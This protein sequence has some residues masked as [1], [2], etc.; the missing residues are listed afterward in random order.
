MSSGVAK[1]LEQLGLGQYAESFEKNAIGLEHL[2]DL[3]HETL[4]EI[5][6]RAVGHRMS[7]LK[8][9]ANLRGQLHAKVA[10]ETD[11]APP[12][13][14]SAEAERRQL[15][16]MFCDLVGS[17]ELSARLDPE[18]MRE[19]LQ[20]YQ[21]TCAAT[22][23][24]YE[25]YIAR[26]VGDGL[27]VYF[28][29]PRAH[30]DDPQR[31]VRAGLAI[32]SDIEALD[33]DLSRSDVTLSVRIGINTGLVVVGDIGSGKRRDT[34]AIV[35]E[36]PNVAARLQALAEP[37]TVVIGESTKRLVEG[38]FVCEELG[39]RQLKGIPQP[40]NAYRPRSESELRTRFEATAAR[41]LT[42]LVGREQEVALLRERWEHAKEGDGQVVLLSG[43]AGI[44]KS[45]VVRA[46]QD[47]IR[48]EARNRVLYYCSPYH[49]NSALYPAIDQMERALRFEK[50]EGV[51]HRLEK[52][53][54]VLSDLGLP[55]NEHAPVLASLLSLPGQGRYPP[56]ALSPE[57]ARGRSLETI[58]AVLG[59][60]ASRAP[61]LMAVEDA[62]WADASTLE[63]LGLVTERASSMALLLIITFRPEFSLPWPAHGGHVTTISLNRLT[64][65]QTVALV[66][67]MVRDDEAL[68]GDLAEHIVA[69]TDGVPLFVEELTKAV[70]E[71]QMR[72]QAR[73]AQTPK[74][75][76]SVMNIP[77]SLQDSLM[78]RLDR[79]GDVKEIAQLGATI[80]R[81]FSFELLRA[82]SPLPEETLSEALSR[83]V[84]SELVYRRSIAPEIKYEF[85]HALV[86]DAAYASLLKSKRQQHHQEIADALE[87]H[88]PHIAKT[89][90]A[91]VA[92]H[93][94]EGGLPAQAV[95]YW[96]KAGE[97]LHARGSIDMSIEAY[98]RVLDLAPDD[99]MRCRG[100]MGVAAGLRILDRYEEALEALEQA[101]RAAEACGLLEER[102]ALHHLRGNLYFPLG[103][104]EAC[105]EQHEL[106][107]RYAQRAESPEAE[108]RAFGG[109]G[110]AEYARGRMITAHRYFTRCVEV[111]RE[112]GFGSI[113]AANAVMLGAAEYYF[114]PSSKVL[115]SAR[116]ALDIAKR[117]GH[118]RAEL[119]SQLLV[120]RMLFEMNE[121]RRARKHIEEAQALVRRFGARRFEPENLNILARICLSEGDDSRA[122][123]LLEEAYELSRQTGIAFTGPRVL[124]SL[125]LATDS[126]E[127]RRW[128][129]EE[130]DRLLRAGA[131]S[132]NY[133]VFYRDAIDLCLEHADWEG[134]ERYAAALEAYT[135]AEPLP[136]S[137]FF[138][139]RGRALAAWRGGHRDE[140]TLQELERVRDKG[141]GLGLHTASKALEQ[142]LAEHPSNNA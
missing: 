121:L 36:T 37:G 90:P 58:I 46:F 23:A 106:A 134:V 76:S 25:G 122:V 108:A 50:D 113:E 112:H 21:A 131:V 129:L 101:E 111:S 57:E 7:I 55:V 120:Y 135:R 4:K 29:Y 81:N 138:V 109:L 32:I 30:E 67:Q 136:W 40:V 126:S 38:L 39:S 89:E 2:P 115:A 9:A 18:D 125:A 14:S 93:Y 26:Y 102:S 82:V 97:L 62:H 69:R 19:L 127:R 83:L 31:A 28:G 52:L 68:P 139:A 114:E 137:D 11:S 141:L 35:G 22:L 59:A 86:R 49:Q 13:L 92:H 87:G 51:E 96:L 54:Q 132:H 3:D 44:G 123:E 119:V 24:R 118:P 15:T 6:I 71:S 133:L 17:T 27:L 66:S 116:A 80:G 43:E 128:A 12:S 63:L 73:D 75:P 117:Y 124:A 84:E 45:R 77:A 8:A 72:A 42:P 56:L 110:D 74:Q 70:L 41:G 88:F 107:L 48:G 16:V 5:G 99:T 79:L 105:R 1:W 60:M 95:R 47:R 64:R 104:I 65:R 34:M 85:K 10:Q 20:R 130:G 103:N 91:L 78:A 94:T 53:D 142:A 100:W 33:T 61:L 98:R 140:A